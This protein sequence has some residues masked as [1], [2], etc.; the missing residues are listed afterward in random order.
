MHKTIRSYIAK[1][2]LLENEKVTPLPEED[3]WD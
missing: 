2:V 1:D 3:Y